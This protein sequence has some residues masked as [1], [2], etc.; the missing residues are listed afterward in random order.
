MKRYSCPFFFF[1]FFLS[2]S[3]LFFFSPFSRSISGGGSK[4]VLCAVFVE[5]GLVAVVLY[6]HTANG[7]GGLFLSSPVRLLEVLVAEGWWW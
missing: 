2:L 6:V 1:L 5:E 4:P 3:S 7:G